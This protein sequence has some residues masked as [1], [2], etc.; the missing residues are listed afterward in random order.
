MPVDFLTAEQKAKFSQFPFEPSEVQLACFFHLDQS[1]LDFILNRRGD[2]NRLGF[3]LQLTS[4]F[5]PRYGMALRP[6]GRLLF[7]VFLLCIGFLC[8][9]R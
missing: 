5:H 7:L 1:D 6:R 8:L 3:A 4:V 9:C 2:Q